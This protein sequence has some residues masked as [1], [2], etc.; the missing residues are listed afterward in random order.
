MMTI[1]DRYLAKTVLLHTLLVMAVLIAL[2]T[3][4]TF[5]SQQDD[6]G[7]GSYDVAG[8][9]LVTLLQMPQQVYQLLPIGALIGAIMGLGGLARDSELTVVRAAGVSVWRIAVS[10]ALAGL[11]VAAFLWVIGEYFAPPADQYARQ[12]KIFSRYSQLEFTGS[13]SAW[14]RQGPLFINVRRQAA[15]NLYGGVYVYRLDDERRLTLVARA[16]TATQD[17]TGRWVLSNY[18]ETQLL[19]DHV[20]ARTLDRL[21]TDQK[22][23]ADFLGVAVT[24][25]GSLPL[26]DLYAY[27]EHLK[28]NNLASAEFEIAF[29][30]RISRLVA[31]VVVC[32]FAVP[33]AFGALRSAG[34]GA[35]TVLGIMVGVLFVLI[36]QTLESSGQVYGLNPLLVAWGPTAL[37]SAVAAVAI[38]RTS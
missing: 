14:V 2:M 32:V 15:E 22:F 4:V 6:I 9:F 28:A 24:Q 8:A 27:K 19:D 3:L 5:I 21:V 7:Q 31:A 33:F 25:P 30:A 37:L 38:W 36:T 26:A 13:R 11:V 29:W 1:L 10:A 12:Y 34:A 16:E 35:R 23:N 18:A 20:A 17:K